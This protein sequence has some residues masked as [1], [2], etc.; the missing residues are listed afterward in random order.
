MND[1]AC[2][3]LQLWPVDTWF[4]RDGTPF[5]AES[6]PQEDV[7][8]VF[9]PH[10]PTI[11]GALR[12][13][14]ARDQGWDGRGR[15]PPELCE[16]LGDGPNLGTLAVDGPFLLRDGE[17]LFRAPRHLIGET[18]N[19]GEWA[20]RALL[21]PGA[22]VQ[23]DLGDNVRLPTLPEA[24]AG[25][26]WTT[27]EDVWLSAD[28]LSTVLR[29]NLPGQRTTFL[30][31]SLW[32]GEPRVGLK[33]DGSTRTAQEGMLYSTVHVRL[34][35]A[36][37]LGLRVAGLPDAWQPPPGILI[38]LGGESRLA[39]CDRWDG[40]LLVRMSPKTGRFMA[41]VALSPLALAQD[42]YQGRQPL[43]LPGGLGEA[44]VVSACLGRPQRIGGWDSLARRPLPMRSVLPPGSVLFCDL[45]EGPGAVPSV[46]EGLLRI[47]ERQEWGFG[48]VAV[49]RW[50]NDR[51]T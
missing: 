32:S 49:G 45:R 13:A 23:C 4:F 18:G 24:D 43:P 31:R 12:A 48:L 7:K 2:T 27:G 8:A 25:S 22:P 42:V 51:E 5:S 20:P 47:G 26:G 41:L 28:G 37:S 14:L 50:P 9:P 39:E 33:R 30:S 46:A 38:P 6:A 17:P 29:G 36:V 19:S 10:P 44:Q 3:G 21:R 34:E 11:V 16:V 40:D 35:H 1:N 15:W